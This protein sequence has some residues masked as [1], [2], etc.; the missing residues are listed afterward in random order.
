MF[1]YI[2]SDTEKNI[3]KNKKIPIEI[4]NYIQENIHNIHQDMEKIRIENNNISILILTI[5]ADFF[6]QFEKESEEK[7]GITNITDFII[8]SSSYRKR[9]RDIKKEKFRFSL[10]SLEDCK[11]QDNISIFLISYLNQFKTNIYVLRQSILNTSNKSGLEYA[12]YDVELRN[13]CTKLYKFNKII[14]PLT[15]KLEKNL[16]EISAQRKRFYLELR[17]FWSQKKEVFAFI[18][19]G[20]NIPIGTKVR[21]EPTLSRQF[22]LK[23]SKINVSFTADGTEFTKL[24]STENV[25]FLK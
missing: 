6:K 15:T 19:K 16:K 20:L 13:F 14:D 3:K 9:G 2:L 21:I 18:V 22:Q 17:S 12:N 11:N 10:S 5:I 25:V 1:N 8:N 4:K 23:N 7:F 24:I